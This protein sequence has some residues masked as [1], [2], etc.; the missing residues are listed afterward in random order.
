MTQ[1]VWL[2]S[3]SIADDTSEDLED[4]N[5]NNEER[6]AKLPSELV[7]ERRARDAS[8]L[9]PLVMPTQLAATGTSG[10]KW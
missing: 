4:L 9:D 1:T 5:A 10:A 3:E 8:F 6:T 7:Q 2:L